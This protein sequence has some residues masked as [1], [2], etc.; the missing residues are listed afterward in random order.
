MIVDDYN[1]NIIIGNTLAMIKLP[2]P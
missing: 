2:G 1:E